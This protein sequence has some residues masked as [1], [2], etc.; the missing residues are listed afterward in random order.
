MKLIHATLYGFGK[1]VDY[2]IDLSS[3]AAVCIYG[4]NE[5]G[6]STLQKFILFMLFGLP[7]KQRAFY[8]PKT[9]GKMGGK[10][11]LYDPIIGEYTIE[12]F[13]EVN[14]GAAVCYTSDGKAYDEAWLKERLQGMTYQTYQSIFSFSAL[15]LNDLRG[16]KED[17]LGEVLLGIGLTGSNNIYSIEK[18]LDTKIGELFKP[19]G[20]KPAI[21][22]QLESLNDLF[23]ALQTYKSEE[24]TYKEK[25]EEIALL[26]KKMDQLQSDLRKEKFRLS[27]IE[28]QQQALPLIHDYQNVS[29]ALEEYPTT[30][31]FPENGVERFETIK[32]KLLPLQSEQAVLKH[33]GQ[34][35]VKRINDLKEE[36]LDQVIYKEAVDILQ[37]K[38]VYVEVKKELEKIDASI[39]KSVIQLNTEIDQL[40]IGLTQADLSSTVFPFH[41]EKTWNQLKND[42][43]QLAIEKEQLRQEENQL[44]HQRNYLLN[45]MQELEDGLLGNEQLQQLNDKVN[46]YKEFNLLQQVKT[47]S[48]L[49]QNNWEKTMAK[50]EVNSR[51]MLIGC[52]MLSLLF[53]ATAIIFT[54]PWLFNVMIIF[55]IIG[56]GQWLWGKHNTKEMK[57]ILGADDS[58]VMKQQISENEKEQAEQLLSRNHQNEV[59]YNAFKEQEKAVNI[60]YIKYSE[61][62]KMLEEK[63]RRLNDQIAEQMDKYAFLK[64]VE[65]PY[66]PE[67]YHRI[68]DLL[69]MEQEQQDKIEVSEQLKSKINQFHVKVNRLSQKI[70]ENI[71]NKSLES[72]LEVLVKLQEKYESTNRQMDQYQSL[73][74]ECNHQQREL[75]QKMQP[76]VIEKKELFL[77]AEVDTENMY[78]EK[79]SKQ[80]D[81]CEKTDRQQSMMEQLDK[82]FPQKEWKQLIKNRTDSPLLDM[83]AQQSHDRID[84]LEKE[85]EVIR[86]R[87][88]EGNASMKTMESSESYSKSIHQYGMEVDHLNKLAKEWAVLK[89]AKDTLIE[90][91]RNYRDKYL[92]KVIENTSLYFKELTGNVY[93]KVYAPI[94]ERPFQLET[95]D[96]MLFTVNEL[97]Q[98]TV[99]QLYVSLRMAI[100]EM[101]S[102]KH[103]LPF[104]IDDAFVHFDTVRTK[105]MMRIIKRIAEKQQIILF[106]CKK[107]VAESVN[108]IDLIFL[109]DTIRIN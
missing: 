58:Q 8:R 16:M 41:I 64:Q 3:E 65:V 59:E 38:Q 55:L 2:S 28:K 77:N 89:T 17:D 18:R 82:S 39:R 48:D 20:K 61:K 100:S 26:K 27:T 86:Q 95:N 81:K 57:K 46:A 69:S 106:T 25:R 9:S 92:T 105:R 94:D 101:M 80:K 10:L 47:T 13:D 40:R 60:Q 54:H 30:I 56:A 23:T 51:N 68:K 12:R 15:D 76:Y 109:S 36:Q 85:V 21:N 99:D 107:E 75:E 63:A 104:I 78:Y 98:G 53:G 22:R 90:A 50:K 44:K 33:N 67:L 4:E 103:H 34:R 43:Y 31:K 49:R 45:Q 37:Q 11:S 72:Q 52:I 35:Y 24:A 66:W 79:A 88:A 14:N 1:W 73:L 6:K 29:A 91:K 42:A 97:S 96:G 84:K 19:Y 108:H 71:A 83:N 5:S 102:K 70:G 93:K 62:K 7:P 87:L 74:A 32:E